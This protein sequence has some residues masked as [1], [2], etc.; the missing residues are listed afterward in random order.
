MA[1]TCIWDGPEP[2]VEMERYCYP[3]YPQGPQPVYH[4]S[5]ARKP[6]SNRV[7]HSTQYPQDQMVHP[8]SQLQRFQQ[9][10]QQQQQQQQYQPQKQQPQQHRQH[11]QTPTRVIGDAHLSQGTDNDGSRAVGTANDAGTA[12]DGGVWK[13]DLDIRNE[14]PCA[15][16]IRFT[17][18]VEVGGVLKYRTSPCSLV[19]ELFSDFIRGLAK[20]YDTP[21]TLAVEPVY[22][23]D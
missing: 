4:Q 8:K 2:F 13:Y 16:S 6:C 23:L 3:G 12:S 18:P 1:R 19:C 20:S 14:G 5:G 22:N 15:V 9:H 7:D 21:A 11:Q 10:H 17:L